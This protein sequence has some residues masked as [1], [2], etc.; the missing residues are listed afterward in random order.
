MVDTVRPALRGASLFG[1]GGG[2]MKKCAKCGEEKPEAD[3]RKSRNG[4]RLGACLD[5]ER[6]RSREYMAKRRA[7]DDDFRRRQIEAVRR[8]VAKNKSHYDA[9]RKDYVKKPE[10]RRRMYDASARWAATERG[11]TSRLN[12]A[13]KRRDR[14]SSGDVSHEDCISVMSRDCCYLCMSDDGDFHLEH[15]VP[16]SRGGPHSLSNLAK[17]CASCNLTKSTM[18]AWEYVGG[19]G[20]EEKAR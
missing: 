13:A 4:G 14:V 9:W 17:A 1:T 3:F 15:M 16:L 11:R 12:S 7:E 6:A 19:F 5:C 18:T 2:A 8:S 20:F 10:V